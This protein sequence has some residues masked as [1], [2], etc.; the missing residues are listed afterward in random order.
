MTSAYALYEA[1]S[2]LKSANAC[3]P[4]HAC[5]ETMRPCPGQ[6]AAVHVHTTG[7]QRASCR[8]CEQ[9]EYLELPLPGR[10]VLLVAWPL[11]CALTRVEPGALIPCEARAV[12]VHRV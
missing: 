6:N 9:R 5:G 8:A 2:R 4:T 10:V 3:L 1:V 7:F 11:C 12:C